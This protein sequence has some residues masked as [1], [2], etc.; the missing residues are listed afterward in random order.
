MPARYDRM[1]KIRATMQAME[2]APE[3][4]ST[5]VVL[6]QFANLDIVQ[7][8]RDIEKLTLTIRS[9]LAAISTRRDLRQLPVDQLQELLDPI[10][11][12]RNRLQEAVVALNSQLETY[13][14]ADDLA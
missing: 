11:K 3:E 1:E 2:V 14:I 4:L 6:S 10:N 12:D 13:V 5:S 9:N 8:V 7:R